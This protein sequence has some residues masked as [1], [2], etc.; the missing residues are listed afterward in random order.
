MLLW[1]RR[2]PGLRERAGRADPPLEVAEDPAFQH[3]AARA[4]AALSA[5]ADWTCRVLA[6]GLQPARV[7]WYRFTDEHGFGS[8]VGRTL[9]APAP[10]RPAPGPLRVRELPER[11]SGRAATPIAG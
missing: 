9:T 6:A 4:E 1:T 3:V 2:P 7:Y 11:D 8:R 5:E 10:R